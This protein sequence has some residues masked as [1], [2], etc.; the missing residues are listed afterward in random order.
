MQRRRRRR[1][2][3]TGNQE[4][5]GGPRDQKLNL[6]VIPTHSRYVKDVE[7]DI[8]RAEGLEI[9]GRGTRIMTPQNVLVV[10]IRC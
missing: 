10:N 2:G 4:V 9:C 7:D 6:V 5:D 1:R 8:G 3:G